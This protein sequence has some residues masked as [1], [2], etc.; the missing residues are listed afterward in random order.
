MDRNIK[1]VSL[2]QLIPDSMKKNHNLLS[3]HFVFFYM[4]MENCGFVTMQ[5]QR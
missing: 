1:D 4:L 3:S 5:K 2:G